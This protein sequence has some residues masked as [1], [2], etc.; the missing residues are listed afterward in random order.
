M[1]VETDYA[2]A[3][4]LMDGE[5]SI[6]IRRYDYKK[7]GHNLP[8][9][10][11]YVEIRMTNKEGVEFIKDTFGGCLTNKGVTKTGKTIYDWK[12]YGNK[13]AAFLENI[14]PYLKCKHRQANVAVKFSMLPNANK[15]NR[16]A[17]TKQRDRMKNL[18]SRLNQTSHGIET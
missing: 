4:G 1:I 9:F 15:E 17:L 3:A 13:A 16:D 11:L 18:I 5:G 14:L 6:C 7:P 2:Y 10:S 12:I 8:A